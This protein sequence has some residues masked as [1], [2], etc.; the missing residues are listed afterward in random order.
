[1]HSQVRRILLAVALTA[2]TLQCAA[3]G[4]EPARVLF[5]LP[6]VEYM[7][8]PH[9]LI[10]DELFPVVDELEEHGVI[11]DFTSPRAAVYPIPVDEA[12]L[13]IREVTVEVTSDLVDL[14]LYALVVIAGGHAHQYLTVLLEPNLSLLQEAY[15]RGGHAGGALPGGHG[16]ER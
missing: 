1:M 10:G 14:S 16:A 5:V 13:H 8:L 9:W 6:R 4:A 7:Y 15:E 2:V 11:I 12:E 3:A